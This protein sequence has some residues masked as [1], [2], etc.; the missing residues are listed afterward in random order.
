M[1]R[2]EPWK[3]G[4]VWL[5]AVV[6]ATSVVWPVFPTGGAI[7]RFGQWPEAPYIAAFYVVAALSLSVPRLLK[8]GSLY[9]LSIASAC[10]ALWVSWRLSPWVGLALIVL[11]GLAF[12]AAR[13][14]AP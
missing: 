12:T 6:L 8:R 11:S 3:L 5:Y 10:L 2:I 1:L 9:A 4:V 14:N 13:A 7:D